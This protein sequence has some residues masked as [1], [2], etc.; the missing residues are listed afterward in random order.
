MK[1]TFW[2]LAA[3]MLMAA[4]VMTSCNNDLDEVAPVEEQNNVV[5]IT[6]ATPATTRVVMNSDGLTI[7]SWAV[8]DVVNLYKATP[9]QKASPEN[10]FRNK[11]AKITGTGVAFTCTNAST[12]TFSGTLPD[13]E[14][15]D[16]YT[17]A[18]FGAT[19]ENIGSMETGII[20]IKPTTWSST[21]LKDVVMMG[22]AKEG[23][24][25]TMKII[26]NVMKIENQSGA[27]VTVA[28]Y[29]YDYYTRNTNPNHYFELACV[30]GPADSETWRWYGNS[31]S[32]LGEIPTWSDVSHF[33]LTDG[34][35]N[36]VNLPMVNGYSYDEIG[37]YT[38][39]ATAVVPMKSNSGRLSNDWKNPVYCGHLL[40]AGT[41]PAGSG[42]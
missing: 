35:V 23:A 5:T 6:I 42:S 26:N 34:A 24:S 33:T 22:A 20:K 3:L 11:P 38:E 39:D 9:G 32:A 10:D 19:A 36:Y 31:I 16:D 1:K 4:P 37:L 25:F 2:S 41:Y 21:D 17:L 30:L 12:G 40:N 29:G 8:G 15:I 27:D 28:W 14:N 18:L 7:A 13:G